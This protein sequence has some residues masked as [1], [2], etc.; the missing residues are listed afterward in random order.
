MSAGDAVVID[1]E[2]ARTR[3]VMERRRT[4][5]VPSPSSHARP[6][7][8][9]ETADVGSMAPTSRPTKST[10]AAVGRPR[11]APGEH[12][13]PWVQRLDGGK[14]VA[15]VRVR[16]RDGRARELSAR[17]TTKGAALREL[18]RRLE[19]RQQTTATEFGV[20]AT[21]TISE[22]GVYWLQHRVRHGLDGKAGAVKPQTLAAYADTIR[23]VLDP[24]L[25]GVRVA[26]L[27]IGLIESVLGDI[28]E[29]GLST[30][31]VRSVLGQMLTLAVRH[32]ALPS[33][34]MLGVATALRPRHE[35]KALSVARAHALR[36]LVDPAARKK[37][38]QRGPNGDLADIVD[39]GLGTGCRIGEILALTWDRLALDVTTPTALI[40]GTLIEPRRGYVETLHRQGTTKGGRDRTLILPDAVAELLERRR[41]QSKFT[42]PGDPVFASGRGTWLWPANI[43]TRLRTAVADDPTLVGTTPHTL[44][45]SVGT[46][47]AHEVSLD[48]AREVLGHS[49]P[50]ITYQLYVERREIAPDVRSTLDQFFI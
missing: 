37:P 17:G 16:N 38:G 33:N 41:D 13:E 39:T 4:R 43:R 14:F 19:A 20:Q 48:A 15:R 27:S 49:D 50:S 28:E 46:L 44:R 1:L 25:G 47:I 18:N 45:R 22:L 40:D 29:L 6:T 5:A 32:G 31:Q 24:H 7:V 26:E 23:L 12:G 10:S 36:A 34:P 42:D 35:V 21:M 30:A 2:A 9:S 11:L 8:I 3:T